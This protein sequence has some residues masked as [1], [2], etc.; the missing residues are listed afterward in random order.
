M[1]AI[2][3]G[4]AI[5]SMFISV[6]SVYY[7]YDR[8]VREIS[9]SV[10]FITLINSLSS[11]LEYLKYEIPNSIFLEQL[12]TLFLIYVPA[13]VYSFFRAFLSDDKSKER[14]DRLEISIYIIT[15]LYSILALTNNLHNLFWTG[16]IENA[17]YVGNLRPHDG[18]LGYTYYVFLAFVM[19][20]VAVKLMRNEKILFKT[21]YRITLVFSILAAINVVA[22][23]MNLSY[24]ISSFTLGLG[25]LIVEFMAV[26]YFWRRDSLGL[27]SQFL[28]QSRDGFIVTDDAGYVIDI[29]QWALN[30]LN[31][32][33]G[34]IIGRKNEFVDGLIKNGKNQII[35]RSG[36]YFLCVPVKFDG[37][38]IVS[39][40]NVS[41]EIF[42]EKQKENL[43]VLLN[44][45]F[46]N[47]P[48]GIAILRRDGKIVDC[49]A[50]FLNM[51][52]YQKV[53]VEGKI[54]DDLIAPENLKTESRELRELA[55]AQKTLKA[56]TIAKRKDGKLIDVRLTISTIVGNDQELL[57][58]IYTDI[59]VEKEVMQVA[60][61][62][63][64]KDLLTG[65]YSR[66]YF[67]R[68]LTTVTEF[69]SSDEHSAI[70]FLDIRDFRTINSSK[71]HT[72]GD[73]V[74]KEIS[75][76]LKSSLRE[77]D[78]VA[79]VDADEFWILIEKAGNSYSAAKERIE[80]I[81]SKMLQELSKPYDIDN[82]R[83]E[84]KFYAAIYIF[85]ILDKVEEIL[86][87][88]NLSLENAKTS[89][90][91][92]VYYNIMMD[93][94]LKERVSK[95]KD[96]RE[97]FYN[98]NVRI[99]LQPICNY[100][101]K[102]VGAEAL[103][104]WIDTNGN[105]IPPA[106]FINNIEENGMIVL[107]GEEVLRQVCE[108]LKKAKDKLPF[109]DV[110]ISPVQLRIQN[111]GDRFSEIILSN[112]VDPKQIVLEITE[113]IL[114]DLNQTVK[115]NIDKLMKLGCQ[116]CIDDFGTGYSSLSYLTLFPLSKIK[117]DRSFVSKLPGD[118]YSLKLL[119]A[120]YDIARS[121]EIDAI[122]E[123][124]E[125]A[126][127]LQILSMIGYKF[128][129]GYYF[130]KPMPVDEFMQHLD[131]NS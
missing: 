129:Q 78:T 1:L 58:A 36:K 82:E 54:I 108:I 90:S 99:F 109:V 98:G 41:S 101:G 69:A 61:N 71:G 87:K 64:E 62:S 35:E 50:S 112:G 57:Y 113:N 42:A 55:I 18:I 9:K 44:S 96:F 53:D 85:S 47:V 43:S 110:N 92:I 107:V 111:M 128:F 95:E 17:Y 24:T 3:K 22:F 59:S 32:S 104:R 13:L 79:R 88:G 15:I 86:R 123:G 20:L 30:F 72:F 29:N 124:V 46:Q 56:N 8:K 4:L 77:V 48:D 97:A 121:F 103:L 38:T 106:E 12:Q 130:A 65:L 116:I 39:I 5:C 80:N 125:N 114:I 14:S 102:I 2:Y 7:A 27:R 70:I 68:K 52:G 74:L 115:N 25:V 10:L 23:S 105:V 21:K 131:K 89:E 81:L 28:E 45:L 118:K 94:E 67:I 117:I 66:F 37:G 83:I 60:K 34:N 93:N 26:N 91:G 119:E 40:R 126:K 19:L 76:R 73:K 11:V 122:P 49:N 120:V 16:T 127:Q 51:F 31:D 75:K 6:F 100:S 33:Y 63:I 84:M